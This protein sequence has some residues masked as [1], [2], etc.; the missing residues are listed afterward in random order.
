MPLYGDSMG[1]ANLITGA[2]GAIETG[3]VDALN[4][5]FEAQATHTEPL[6]VWL[7]GGLVDKAHGLEGAGR[8]ATHFQAHDISALFVVW[9]TGPLEIIGHNLDEAIREPIFQSLLQKVLSW[10]VGKLDITGGTRAVSTLAPVPDHKLFANGEPIDFSAIEDAALNGEGMTDADLA[11]FEQ[12]IMADAG[13]QRQL[14]AIAKGADVEVAEQHSK[15]IVGA[16]EGRS[17]RMDDS[18]MRELAREARMPDGSRGWIPGWTWF[19]K[20]AAMILWRVVKRTVQGRH[21]GLYCTVIEE[22]AREFYLT[23]A[24]HFL[25]ATIKNESADTFA[26]PDRGGALLVRKLRALVDA[27]PGKRLCLV[28]HSA[29]SIW[30]SSLL[31]ALERDVDTLVFLAPAVTNERFAATLDVAE[32]HIKRF[33]LY[34]MSDQAE[35]QDQVLGVVYPRSLLYL[36]SGAAEDEVDA[37]LLGMDRFLRTVA[38]DHEPAFRDDG[39]NRVRA[40]L[41]TDGQLSTSARAVW[42]SENRGPGLHSTALAHGDF[43]NDEATLASIVT[44]I[45]EAP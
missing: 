32:P 35:Q 44:L 24:G 4:A 20:K 5:F 7:H 34:T 45:Q 2:D 31:E 26:Q 16:P 42:S 3:S 30:L 9:Q 38:A 8:L 10:A 40:F 43:D 6:V 28:G 36:V 37:P 27:N 41:Q 25:W 17:T 29:G 1:T 39:T 13:I 19:A 23:A 21:H 33:R 11:T 14:L 12:A 15:S 18:V 22:V